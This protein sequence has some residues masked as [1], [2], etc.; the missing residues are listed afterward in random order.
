MVPV[1]VSAP[2]SSYLCIGKSNE[3]T[4]YTVCPKRGR[5]KK[6]DDYEKRSKQR[7]LYAAVP[8]VAL[9]GYGKRHNVPTAERRNPEVGKRT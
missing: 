4:S 6:Q 2:G 5:H 1:A 7:H 9:S 3:R 8:F